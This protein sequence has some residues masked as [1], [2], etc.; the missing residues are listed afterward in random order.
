MLEED[1]LDVENQNRK[2]DQNLNKTTLAENTGSM[3]TYPNPGNPTTSIHYRLS[4]IGRVKIYVFN[5]LG[6]EIQVLVNE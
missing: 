5:M 3:Q 1:I 4:K 6:Q 2:K